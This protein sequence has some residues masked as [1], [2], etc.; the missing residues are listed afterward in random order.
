MRDHF[1]DH[2]ASGRHSPGVFVVRP[3][4]SYSE[5]VDFLV[6]A[7]YASEPDEWRD[8]VEFIP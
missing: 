5:V 8:R 3:F 2:L 4:R 6:L 7:A 1:L